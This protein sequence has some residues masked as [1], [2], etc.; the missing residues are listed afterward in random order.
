MLADVQGFGR[1]W[2]TATTGEVCQLLL[3]CESGA[4]AGFAYQLFRATAA[5]WY[6]DIEGARPT[7]RECGVRCSSFHMGDSF[8]IRVCSNTDREG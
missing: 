3:R 2:G 8:V 7:V 1:V 5:R 6:C 4:S